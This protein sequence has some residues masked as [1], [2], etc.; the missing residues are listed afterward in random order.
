[1]V[2]V[3]HDRVGVGKSAINY[4]ITV[5]PII[6]WIWI[7]IGIRI[8]RIWISRI[9]YRQTNSNRNPHARLGS[10]KGRKTKSARHGNDQEKLL[11]IHN[12]TSFIAC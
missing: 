12:F 2:A 4:P 9:G 5:R 8:I 1:M 7:A 11:P 10:R 3:K 6:V